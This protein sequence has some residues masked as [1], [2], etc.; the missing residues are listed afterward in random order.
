MARS[1]DCKLKIG[2]WRLQIGVPHSGN[3]QFPIFNLQS[4]IVW[5]FSTVAVTLFCAV[6][7]SAHEI[8]VVAHAHGTTI[9]GEAY[10]HGKAPARDAKVT[11]FDSAGARI[12]ETTTDEEGRFSLQAK[13][14]C[15]HRLLVDAG[16]G[17][18]AECVV[19]AAGLPDSLPARNHAPLTH[20]SLGR[21]PLSLAAPSQDAVLEVIRAEI[22]GLRDTLE[23]YERRTRLRDILGG[24]GYIVGIAGV[25]FYL[26]GVRRKS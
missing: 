21:A 10:F 20:A 15:D 3:L 18:G 23:L 1:S 11:A 13:Y 4:S 12:G 24:I 22:A 9:H 6:P 19:A 17:H 16:D 2:N 26:L 7:A 5:V 14:R 8:H 25:A